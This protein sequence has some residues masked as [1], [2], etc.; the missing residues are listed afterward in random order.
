MEVR[1]PK[2]YII[3][4]PPNIESEYKTNK[5]PRINLSLEVRQYRLKFYYCLSSHLFYWTHQAYSPLCSLIP[6][7][8]FVI[9]FLVSISMVIAAPRLRTWIRFPERPG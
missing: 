8:P 7:S 3:H 4:L 5:P 1:V 9:D 2:K 6:I